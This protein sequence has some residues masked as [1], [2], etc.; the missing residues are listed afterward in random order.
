LNLFEKSLSRLSKEEG[1]EKRRGGG[2]RK[3]FK[4]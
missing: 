2:E 3:S 1:R 4:Q